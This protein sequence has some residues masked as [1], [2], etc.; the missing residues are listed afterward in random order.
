MCKTPSVCKY[1]HLSILECITDF[2]VI[3]ANEAAHRAIQSEAA[4]FQNRAADSTKL[5]ILED[6]FPLIAHFWEGDRAENWSLDLLAVHPEYAGKGHA[7]PLVQFG[8]DEARKEGIAT[9][10]S[11]AYGVEPFYERLGF[12]IVG[13]AK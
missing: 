6:C 9:S 1:S 7:R 2:C 5:N 8:I 13:R 3:T 10:V 4:E 12:K 11:S